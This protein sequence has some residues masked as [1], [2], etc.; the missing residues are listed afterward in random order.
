MTTGTTAKATPGPWKVH[1]DSHAV[2][3][4]NEPFMHNVALLT[5]PQGGTWSDTIEET[6]ANARLISQAPALLNALEVAEAT[7]NRLER[8][9]PGSANGT[10]NVI[11]TAIADAT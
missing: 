3:V 10:L 9:A 2:W 4:S 5:K 11:R 1:Q 8:H 6:E 7:I